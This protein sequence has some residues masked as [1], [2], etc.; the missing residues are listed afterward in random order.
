MS[1]DYKLNPTAQW[2]SVEE[3]YA[4]LPETLKQFMHNVLPWHLLT[5]GVGIVVPSTLDTIVARVEFSSDA[6]DLERITKAL[7]EVHLTYRGALAMLCGFSVNVATESE[8]EFVK[9]VTKWKKLGLPKGTT[10]SKLWK[11]LDLC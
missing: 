10:S 11:E 9:R 5:V 8:S 7:G 3:R 6:R 1:L 4:L 2:P